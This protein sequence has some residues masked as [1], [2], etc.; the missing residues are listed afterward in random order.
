MGVDLPL[1]AVRR[2]FEDRGPWVTKFRIG[3]DDYGGDY[4]ALS[5]VRIK[6]FRKAFRRVRTVLELGSMEGGHSNAL[7]RLRGVR[8]TAV[9][10]RQA[11]IERARFV[12]NLLGTP[13]IEFVQADLEAKSV[14]S[15]GTFDAVFCSGLLYHLPQPW[16]LLDELRDVAPN[17]FLWTHYAEKERATEV[18]HGL[19]GHWYEENPEANPLDGLSPKSY[20]LTL[21]ALVGRLKENGFHRVKIINDD[22]RHAI[23]PTVTL[24]ARAGR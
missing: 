11:N 24:V 17:L 23:G 19:A 1:E 5:D 21:P 10:G 14:A 2:G 16:R 15:F 12:T 18:M 7:A 9:E 3:N 4:D 22:R 13:N 20:W 8:V 6:Q